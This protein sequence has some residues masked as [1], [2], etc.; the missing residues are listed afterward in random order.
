M[1]SSVRNHPNNPACQ[2]FNIG[3]SRCKS[4]T[5][6]WWNVSSA[7]YFRNKGTKKTKQAFSNED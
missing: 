3:G 7:N 5:N 6:S 4:K 2:P 1:E